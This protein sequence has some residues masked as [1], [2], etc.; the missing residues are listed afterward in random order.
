MKQKQWLF[1]LLAGLILAGFP[2]AGTA[3][4][5]TIYLKNKKTVEGIILSNEPD[6][7]FVVIRIPAGPLK[8]PR[9]NIERID[10]QKNIDFTES[11]GDLAVTDNDLD[12]A[13]QLYQKA[14][15]DDPGNKRLADK[16]EKVRKNIA[17][18]DQRVY[19]TSF[20]KI[21]NLLKNREFQPAI[22]E[23][24][25]LYDRVKE[26]S[27]RDR[28]K[29][30][31]AEA[32]I[33]IAR[34]FKDRVDYPNAEKHYLL[35]KQEYP[36]NPLAAIELADMLATGRKPQAIELYKEGIQLAKENPGSLGP[37]HDAKLL[38]YQFKLG[39]LYFEDKQYRA[40]ADAFVEVTRD[41]KN[42]TKPEAVDYA[43]EAYSKIQTS[44]I[45]GDI[46]HI[47]ENLK[48]II[49]MR[50]REDRASLLLGRIYFDQG[51]WAHA[52]ETL[53]QAVASPPVAAASNL[54]YQEAL[55]YLGISYRKLNQVDKAAEAFQNLVN[56]K[57]GNY[58]AYCELGEVR[59]LQAAYAQA[60]DAFDQALALDK[61]KYRAW[62][63]KGRALQKLTP[64]QYDE[65]RECLKEVVLR[66]PGNLDAQ[67]S[68]ATSYIDEQR[69][70]DATRELQK[71]IDMS[72]DKSEA[73][74]NKD[75]IKQ[76][77]AQA[78]TFLGTANLNLLKTNVAREN[79][80]QALN[81]ISTY[82]PAMDGIGKTYQAEGM[83]KEA[84]TNF[85]KAIEADPKNPDYYLSLGI[86][87]HKYRKNY[88]KAL[89]YYMK[90]LE[91]GGKDPNV[92]QWIRE[93][94]GTPPPE[95]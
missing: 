90:Y 24:Q 10:Q 21:E 15:K 88:A 17:D 36:K 43:V 8:I 25:N 81:I 77:L 1:A 59:L 22:D 12:R 14:L 83:Q 79:F 64:P 53:S 71:T 75:E 37:N 51:D 23:A 76:V 6:S 5:D 87:W 94:G 35:A 33:G 31:I 62:L 38:D 29:Q 72:R 78:N 26:S 65:S 20:E 54:P 19:G 68:I 61:D 42:F 45:K 84:E 47:I 60:K 89:T 52:A 57:T 4:G 46:N 11:T 49:A 30:L 13:M 86:N 44:A 58:D 73:E 18:R 7:Q 67:L 69:W 55:Y 92:R 9:D 85:M 40:A 91:L 16:I 80:Q 48:A 41:D 74:R 93:C 66:D 27:A 56:Q 63:G 32:H 70:N 2:G 39:R 34:D 82:A 3:W 95:K 28:C 50:Q